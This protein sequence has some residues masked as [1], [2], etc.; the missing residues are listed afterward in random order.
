MVAGTVWR[1]EE[2]IG[3]AMGAFSPA[4]VAFVVYPI[5]VPSGKMLWRAKF[6]ETQRSLFEN[7]L[8]SWAFLKKGAKWLSAD[9][10]ARYGVREVFKKS[11]L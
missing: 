9:E 10:L 1:Y 2:R 5:D 11:H 4:S 3:G 8:D 6:D 7:V